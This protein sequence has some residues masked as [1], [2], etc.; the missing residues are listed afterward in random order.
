MTFTVVV[1]F[2]ILEQ[3]NTLKTSFYVK[4]TSYLAQFQE[5]RQTSLLVNQL[6]HFKSFDNLNVFEG[7]RV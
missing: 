3:I 7:R 6:H 4:I 5:I 2:I 1:F